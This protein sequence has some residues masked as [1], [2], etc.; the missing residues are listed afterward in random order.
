MGGLQ[1]IRYH[2]CFI[3]CEFCSTRSI[4]SCWTTAC[5]GTVLGCLTQRH[6]YNAPKFQD[7]YAA[8]TANLGRYFQCKAKL[9]PQRSPPLPADTAQLAGASSHAAAGL[10]GT[11]RDSETHQSEQSLVSHWKLPHSHIET[12]AM[13]VSLGKWGK[14]SS[15]ST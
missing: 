15:L 6:L 7:H 14:T 12:C 4:N 1:K 11:R 9:G 5:K 13:T 3:H 2:L 10:G 8:Q